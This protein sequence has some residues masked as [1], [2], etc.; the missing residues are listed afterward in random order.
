MMQKNKKHYNTQIHY[1]SLYV[2]TP[3]CLIAAK[4]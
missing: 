1:I 4:V 2:P 3:T